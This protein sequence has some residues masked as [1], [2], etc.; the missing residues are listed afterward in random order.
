MTR[1]ITLK[2]G[3]EIQEIQKGTFSLIF[4]NKRYITITTWKGK[5]EVK[6]PSVGTFEV[7]EIDE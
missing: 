6:I 1:N 4:I 2:D 3:T 5:V 7:G